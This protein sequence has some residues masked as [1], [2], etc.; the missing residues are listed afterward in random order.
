MVRYKFSGPYKNI[1]CRVFYSADEDKSLSGIS[2]SFGDRYNK[3]YDYTAWR[4]INFSVYSSFIKALGK[5]HEFI[6]KEKINFQAIWKNKGYYININPGFKDSAFRAGQ[7]EIS[8]NKK[9]YI[10]DYS[11]DYFLADKT[12]QVYKNTLY[13]ELR[14]VQP[15]TKESVNKAL[16]QINDFQKKKHI[17][18]APQRTFYRKYNFGLKNN[19]DLMELKLTTDVFHDAVEEKPAKDDSY[20][21]WIYQDGLIRESGQAQ[22]NGGK[23]EDKPLI[24]KYFYD[25]QKL[26]RAVISKDLGQTQS[27]WVEYD[28]NGYL[29]R[30]THFKEK[31]HEGTFVY[32]GNNYY[33]QILAS[34]YDKTNQLKDA[35]I[36]SGKFYYRGSLSLWPCFNRSWIYSKNN[37][38]QK[39]FKLSTPTPNHNKSFT[40]HP[41][42]FY[43]TK[44]QLAKCISQFEDYCQTIST[45]R[46]WIKKKWGEEQVNPK[47][48]F[49]EYSSHIAHI[50]KAS[51]QLFPVALVQ[52]GRGVVKLVDQ[53]KKY[54]IYKLNQLV[55]DR[56]QLSTIKSDQ[57]E[58]KDLKTKKVLKLEKGKALKLGNGTIITINGEKHSVLDGEMF[59]GSKISIKEDGKFSLDDKELKTQWHFF[60]P[61]NGKS[62]HKIAGCTCYSK[63]DKILK[64]DTKGPDRDSLIAPAPRNPILSLDYYLKNCF[65]Y[66]DSYKK[67]HDPKVGDFIN[68]IRSTSVYSLEKGTLISGNTNAPRFPGV[69]SHTLKMLGKS[70]YIDGRKVTL[71]KGKY[72][73]TAYGVKIDS[74]NI[75]V[76]RFA[77]KNFKSLIRFISQS[78]MTVI[79]STY[80][81]Y[82]F[83]SGKRSFYIAATKKFQSENFKYT[84]N[85]KTS[86]LTINKEVCKVAFN[87]LEASVTF[88]NG[89][90]FILSMVNVF[91]PFG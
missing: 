82:R 70:L 21:Y 53:K 50:E 88:P 69:K 41:K 86:E 78:E 54:S 3:K 60:A 87:D 77:P 6:V 76:L 9:R 2:I 90:K 28:E 29:S 17:L 79:N 45:Y 48:L 81:Q 80:D 43:N 20:Y 27:Y 7:C 58:L 38:L 73:D 10:T 14:K 46:A 35:H 75:A 8:I 33:S 57:I 68:L 36:K 49:T 59:L 72:S 22:I 1:K 15:N 5:P 63:E 66:V 85:E 11:E 26:L 83:S 37:D 30:V 19:L 74:K 34:S 62:A 32:Y 56:Y 61:N 40:V 12:M 24:F 4:K 16:S 42:V 47:L 64:I 18:D 65:I 89:I 52:I 44:E 55:L 71:L 31:S 67:D 25:E 84:L 13:K 39:K 51:E 23:V 91:T